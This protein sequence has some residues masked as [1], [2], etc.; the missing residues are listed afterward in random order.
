MA[1]NTLLDL[2]NMLNN[3]LDSVPDAPDFVTPPAGEYRL[4]VKDCA[5][6]TYETKKEPGVQ[7]Q[8]LKMTYTIVQT[9]S[10][11]NNEQPVP[12]GSIFTETFMATEQ[13]LGYFKKRIKEIMNATDVVGVTLADMMNS[14]KGNEFAARLTIKKSVV[15]G[16]E[17]E[18]VQ[19]R[20]INQQ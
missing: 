1:E 19:L 9:I 5:V 13:G 3:N 4:S 18:N 7:K 6:D 15:S 12:D 17:Y 10:T 14:V 11:L 8:R 20:V 2:N 16:T